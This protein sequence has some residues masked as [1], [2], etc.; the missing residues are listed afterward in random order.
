LSA[1]AE[2]FVESQE[3]KAR[4]DYLL[5]LRD[6]NGNIL[7][8]K[9]VLITCEGDGSLQPSHNAKDLIRETN[10][11]GQIKFQWFRRGIFGRDV[12]AVIVVEGRDEGSVVTL[13]SV[14]PEYSSTS[15]RT[16]VYPFKTGGKSYWPSHR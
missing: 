1:S 5:T 9:D 8:G 15:Y 13:E 3:P 2:I 11:E 16:K 7:A 12:K 6:A 10:A 4:F 14:E